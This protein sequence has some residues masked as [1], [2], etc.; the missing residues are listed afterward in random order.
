MTR[1]VSVNNG[2][3]VDGS[4]LHRYSVGMGK[5]QE[6]KPARVMQK[7]KR[8]GMG[9]LIAALAVVL[10]CAACALV[11]LFAFPRVSIVADSSF[12]QVVPSSDLIR[13]RLNY[14]FGGT[15]LSVVKLDDQCFSFKDLFVNAVSKIKGKTVVLSPMVSEYAIAEDVDVSSVLEQSTVIGITV[16]KENTCFDCILI[17]DE[18]PGWLDASSII[19]A[20]TSKMS[21]NVALV[22]SANKVSYI[23]D[24]IDA[25]PAGHVSVF[26]KKGS[27]AIFASNTLEEMDRQGIVLALCPYVSTFYRFFSNET[28]VQWVVD[29]R[30]ASVVPEKNLYAVVIPD[31]SGL[32]YAA[33]D[34]EKHSNTLKT[35][36][37]IYVKR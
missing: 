34:V 22:Y 25:F 16:D 31:F 17:P 33:E 21:Q 6:K 27:S 3:A 10:F 7:K 13:L 23:Q 9:A 35:L 11:Y 5:K 24:I 8:K 14:A 4:A 32:Q 15:R 26:E 19:E 30:F 36:P 29:Y 12:F 2:A 37:Y 18:L 20:E 1:G 28:T